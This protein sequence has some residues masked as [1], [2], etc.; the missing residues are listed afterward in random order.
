MQQ[1]SSSLTLVFRLAIPLLWCTFF[2]GLG[3]ALIFSDIPT[4]TLPTTYFAIAWGLFM[5]AGLLFFYFTFWKIYR[6]DGDGSHIYVSNYWHTYR[7]PLQEIEDWTWKQLGPWKL[8][9]IKL[10]SKGSLGRK[11]RFLG[12]RKGID[13]YLRSLGLSI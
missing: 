8:F 12:R 7:Y 13:S 9:T 4:L 1:L 5:L 6:I 2:G 10:V 11:I 3:L